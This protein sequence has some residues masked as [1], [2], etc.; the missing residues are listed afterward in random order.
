MITTTKLV[1]VNR[2]DIS[3]YMLCVVYERKTN[4]V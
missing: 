2:R 1:T 4:G 3:K